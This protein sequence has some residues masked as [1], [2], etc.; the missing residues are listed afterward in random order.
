MQQKI[1]FRNKGEIKNNFRWSKTENSLPAYLPK[2]AKGKKIKNLGTSE[3]EGKHGKNKNMDKYNRL[4]FF[5][6]FLNYA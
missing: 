3:K 5:M 2:M 4:F 6:S 1:S